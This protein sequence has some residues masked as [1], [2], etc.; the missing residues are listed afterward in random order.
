[1]LDMEMI[2]DNDDEIV[3]FDSHLALPLFS[4]TFE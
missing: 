4:I 3:I 2:D 1:M